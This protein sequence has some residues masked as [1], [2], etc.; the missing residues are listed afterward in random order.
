MLLSERRNSQTE[1]QDMCACNSI[2]ECR[3][4]LEQEESTRE[5]AERGQVL[6]ENNTKSEREMNK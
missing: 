5:G 2:S 1:A 4:T 6:R 3:Q